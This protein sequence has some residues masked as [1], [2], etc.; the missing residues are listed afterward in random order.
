MKGMITSIS[1]Q[2]LIEESVRRGACRQELLRKIGVS[3]GGSP[4]PS[5][6]VSLDS[7]CVLWEAALRLTGDEMLALHT[8][9][10]LPFGIYRLLDFMF[11]ASA[12]PSDALE[13][14]SRSFGLMNTAFELLF[15][16]RRDSAS[17][18]LHG[19]SATE[20]LPRPYVEYILANYLVRLRFA[21]Q[22]ACSPV[23]VHVTY[24]RPSRTAEYDRIFGAPV[25]FRQPANRM[26]F[27]RSL[28]ALRQPFADT[29][30]C[31][32]LEEHAR[33]KLSRSGSGPPT[34]EHVRQAMAY[35]LTHG[36]ATLNRLSAQLAMSTRSLQRNIQ[37]NGM[38]FRELLDGVR[39]D[40]APALLQ[41][42]RL[43][44]KEVA[45]R[46]RFSGAGSF[47]HAFRR[48]TGLSP[49]AYRKKLED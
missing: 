4:F 46:L 26:V 24:A 22:V 44:V 29:E 6:F 49:T 8:A 42:T 14:T 32:L 39:R 33:Q 20:C 38:T 15:R 11:A 16:L 1:P 34:L 41:D 19:Q 25:R 45:A 9:E 13:R 17:L 5:G 27:S 47:S 28:L 43:S 7:M 37:A 12:T 18:E 40:R 3:P 35:S 30:L 10:K 23:E 31:E 21:T 48:W 36:E 2:I